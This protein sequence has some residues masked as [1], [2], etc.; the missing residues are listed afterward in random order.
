M[1]ILCKEQDIFVTLFLYLCYV[2]AYLF[3]FRMTWRCLIIYVYILKWEIEKREIQCRRR[4]GLGN[5]LDVTDLDNTECLF[6]CSTLCPLHNILFNHW[7]ALVIH[8]NIGIFC[9]WC[10]SLN[11]QTD[12]F[13]L[14]PH[15]I[16]LN[17]LAASWKFVT[18]LLQIKSFHKPI[19]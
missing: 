1:N 5:L 13:L 4:K 19:S 10:M 6:I 11:N 15:S 2:P 17:K 3:L 16:S 14:M 18:L 9:I 12:Y 8:T 7:N